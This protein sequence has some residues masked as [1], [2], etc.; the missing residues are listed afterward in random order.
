[1]RNYLLACDNLFERG[2]LS[3]DKM[4]AGDQSIIELI[5]DGYKYFEDYK[6][7]MHAASDFSP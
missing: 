4:T 2:L 6:E 5:D 7:G 1:M 3:N